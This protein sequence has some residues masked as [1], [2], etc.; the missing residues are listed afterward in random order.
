LKIS[1][2]GNTANNAYHNVK[3]LQAEENVV[4]QLPVRMFGLSHPI[5]APAWDEIDF[6]VP[7]FEWISEPD[8]SRFPDAANV[9][10]IFPDLL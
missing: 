8:W 4:S 10:S 2:F 9:N 5:S 3:I 6:E 7:D 1:H